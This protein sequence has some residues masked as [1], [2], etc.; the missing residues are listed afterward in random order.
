MSASSRSAPAALLRIYKLTLSPLFMA[1]G[2]RCRHE[3]SCSEYAAE[4]VERYGLIKGGWMGLKRL[5]RCRP[6]GTSGWDPVP[7]QDK[8]DKT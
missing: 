2:A 1:L 8:E 4:A 6:G 5:S 3:P 7:T